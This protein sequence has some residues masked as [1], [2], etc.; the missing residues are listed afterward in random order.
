MSSLGLKF[1]LCARYVSHRAVIRSSEKTFVCTLK[2]T[3]MCHFYPSKK[4]R[5]RKWIFGNRYLIIFPFHDT[6]QYS[7]FLIYLYTPRKKEYLLFLSSKA[8]NARDFSDILPR[9]FFNASVSPQSIFRFIFRELLICF[10]L[11]LRLTDSFIVV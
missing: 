6:H 8:T 10:Q 11:Q 1:I 9:S 3:L 4:F 5:V 7:Y 2:K